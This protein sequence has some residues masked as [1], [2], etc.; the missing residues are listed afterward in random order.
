MQK[1]LI[2]ITREDGSNVLLPSNNAGVQAVRNDAAFGSGIYYAYFSDGTR[3]VIGGP[4]IPVALFSDTIAVDEVDVPTGGNGI[5][6]TNTAYTLAT[7]MQF[8]TPAAGI[9]LVTFAGYYF[10]GLKNSFIFSSIFSGGVRAPGSEQSHAISNVGA[11][12][13]DVIWTPFSCNARVTVDGT[14]DI[15]G[16]WKIQGQPGQ[17]GH[18]YTRNITIL[19][20][21]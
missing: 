3:E 15:E 6:T 8:V 9:Y 20:V 1:T 2:N 16:M 17:T 14:Q 21:S 13:L 4:G 11:A 19:K 18:M 12:D 10:A 7:G 5:T